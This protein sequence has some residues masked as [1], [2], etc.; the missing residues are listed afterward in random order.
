MSEFLRRLAS[1]LVIAAFY[2]LYVSVSG[3]EVVASGHEQMHAEASAGW[4]ELFNKLMS[5]GEISAVMVLVG[6]YVFHAAILP[7]SGV[8]KSWP[9]I[10]RIE[11]IATLV[12]LY[13]MIFA[14]SNNTLTLVRVTI[15]IIWLLVAWKAIPHSE[16]SSIL[17]GL[18]ALLIIPLLHIENVQTFLSLQ[19]VVLVLL[20]SIHTA[21]GAIWFGG[22]ISFY[23]ALARK[24]ELPGPQVRMLLARF[25]T[26]TA[27]ALCGIV[28]TSLINLTLNSSMWTEWKSG[29][30]GILVFLKLSLILV[31]VWAVTKG[32]RHWKGAGNDETS[33]RFRYKQSLRFSLSLTVLVLLISVLISAPATG[34]PVLKGPVYWHV[35]GETAHMSLR[36][37]ERSGGVQHVTLDIWL[38]TGMGKPVS[39]EVIFHRDHLSAEASM[40]YMQGGPDP[41]G[42]IGFDKYTY[43]TEGSYITEKGSWIMEVKAIDEAGRK[44]TYEKVEVIP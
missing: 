2:L 43:E 5:F 22:G 24:P 35:M 20:D 25:M 4:P 14:G 9:K 7:A 27:A 38:P 19:G 13:A 23:A 39:T 32:Y 37:R 40:N 1:T 16:I 15:A 17:K 36:V 41:Y 8:Y 29:P 12:T 33:L 31:M 18:C 34:A 11:R 6:V 26:W 3:W 30:N 10:E 44:H 28:L 21:S 42:F